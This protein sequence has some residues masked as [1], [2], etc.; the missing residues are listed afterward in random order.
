MTV[1]GV[2]AEFGVG[3]VCPPQK[4]IEEIKKA[5]DKMFLPGVQQGR[6]TL[7]A[8][9]LREDFGTFTVTVGVWFDVGNEQDNNPLGELTQSRF[10]AAG[11][12][13]ALRM[14]K[15]A[16]Q[17]AAELAWSQVP[18]DPDRVHLDDAIKVDIFQESI[19]TKITGSKDLPLLPNPDFTHR[20]KDKLTLAPQGSRQALAFEESTDTDLDAV[21]VS[22]SPGLSRVCC[23]PFSEAH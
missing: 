2:H 7:A 22:P 20:I 21:K 1:L 17:L 5:V 19:I 9:T 11:N 4:D 15:D 23:H 13:A 8:C 3:P 14:T 10:L 12:T 6:R 18:K 16:M